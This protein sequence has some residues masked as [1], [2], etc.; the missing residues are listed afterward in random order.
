M[1]DCRQN[2]K[3]FQEK[4]PFKI[5]FPSKVYSPHDYF[6]LKENSLKNIILFKGKRA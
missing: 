3:S 5:K 2:K 6:F 1:T 4:I